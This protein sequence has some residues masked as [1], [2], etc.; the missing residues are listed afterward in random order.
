MVND[1]KNSIKNIRADQNW[2]PGDL[3]TKSDHR[4]TAD[5][6]PATI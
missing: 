4:M 6:A 2:L 1:S 3:A 5:D